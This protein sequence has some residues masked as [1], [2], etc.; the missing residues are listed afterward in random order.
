MIKHNCYGQAK[1]ICRPASI[2][3]LALSRHSQG[4]LVRP[5]SASGSPALSMKR[6]WTR[7]IPQRQ[8][9]G[10]VVMLDNRLVKRPSGTALLVPFPGLA[11]A[12]AQEWQEV[13]DDFTPHDLPLTQLTCTA[14]ERVAPHR[15]EIVRALAAYGLNDLLCYR[16][17][18]PPSLVARQQEVWDPWL[19]WLETVHGIRLVTTTGIMPVHQP[20]GTSEALTSLL[21]QQTDYHLAALGVLVPGLGSFVLGLA[22]AQAALSPASSCEAA[23]LDQ[24][25]QAN[26]WGEDPKDHAQHQSLVADAEHAV[27]FIQCA[28]P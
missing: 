16:A 8:E 20:P 28:R 7:A 23:A 12:I 11:T 3:A 24:L 5:V 10:Y 17:A 22:A 4:N 13:A 14:Q 1:I 2:P 9:N 25:W 6:F 15:A 18:H 27:R 21:A 26:L 19:L